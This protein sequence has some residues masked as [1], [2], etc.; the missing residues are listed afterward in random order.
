M[1]VPACLC[2]A[3]VFCR[4]PRP[5]TSLVL[6]ASPSRAGMRA[7]INVTASA[8]ATASL[9]AAVAAAPAPKRYFIAAEEIEWDYVPTGKDGCTGQAFE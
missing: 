2:W 4:G 6:H 7:L 9:N 1:H 8:E 3:A 5:P